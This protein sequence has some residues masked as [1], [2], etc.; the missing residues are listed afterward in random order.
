MV[1]ETI[2]NNF[3]N[4]VQELLQCSHKPGPGSEAPSPGRGAPARSAVDDARD[5]LTT[6][7]SMHAQALKETRHRPRHTERPPSE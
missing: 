2:E 5:Q 1:T 6:C 3:I 7:E 4:S